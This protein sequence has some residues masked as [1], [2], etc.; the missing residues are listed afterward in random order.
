MES[1]SLTHEPLVLSQQPAQLVR[2]HFTV[3]V[4]G[5]QDG[6]SANANP[7]AAPSAKAL[8]VRLATEAWLVFI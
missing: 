4:P 2:L 5:P 8:P 6:T 7:R 3:V 1:T